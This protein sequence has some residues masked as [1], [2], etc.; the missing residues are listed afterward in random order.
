MEMNNANREIMEE[1]NKHDQGMA[2]A[3]GNCGCASVSQAK[4][5][6]L[7]KFFYGIKLMNA[8]PIRFFIA[9]TLPG[10]LLQIM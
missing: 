7:Q 9:F 10:D 2:P 8:K 4:H 5:L 3:H 1:R 6:H